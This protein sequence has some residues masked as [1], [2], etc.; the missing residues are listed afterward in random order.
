MG[1]F[2]SAMSAINDEAIEPPRSEVSAAATRLLPRTVRIRYHAG[3]TL[4]SVRGAAKFSSAPCLPR[5]HPSRRSG[6][7]ACGA[8]KTFFF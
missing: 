3:L 5:C 1:V 4:F 6:V 7:V 8:V 2:N